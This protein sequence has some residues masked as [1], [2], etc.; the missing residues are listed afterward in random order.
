MAKRGLTEKII[1]TNSRKKRIPKYS[2]L[3]ALEGNNKTEKLYLSHFNKRE[4]PYYIIFAKGNETDPLSM[5]KSLI[6]E[7]TKLEIDTSSKDKV[8]CVFDADE[9]SSKD[10]VIKNILGLCEEYGITIITS[11]PCFEEWIL[12]HYEPSTRPLTNK[13]CLKKLKKYIPNYEKNL[14]VY[15]I[16]CKFTNTAIQNAK[17]KEEYH[18]KQGR[19]IYLTESNPST[20]FY[21]IIEELTINQKQK[22]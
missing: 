20:L 6:K 14:D 10:K 5:V 4:N 19:N 15:P 8:Y 3:I 9:S 16:I 17:I 18:K 7:M 2:I 12:S 1:K 13:E 22:Q 21:K 11:N